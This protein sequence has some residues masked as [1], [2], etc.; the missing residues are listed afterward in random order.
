VRAPSAGPRCRHAVIA[1]ALLLAIAGL[2][3]G[4]AARAALCGYVANEGSDSVSVV[5]LA[6]RRVVQTLAVGDQPTG[7]AIT[8]TDTSGTVVL[9]TNRAAASLSILPLDGT[10][11][12]AVPLTSDPA[13]ISAGA[14]G[15]AYIVHPDTA[16]LTVVDVD[17]IQDAT[18]ISLS[19]RPVAV[20]LAESPPLVLLADESESRLLVLEE[21]DPPLLQP[22]RVGSMPAAIAVD[23]ATGL[24]YVSATPLTVIDPAN[25]DVKG[26]VS[27]PV[28]GTPAGVAMS[29]NPAAALLCVR[30]PTGGSVQ[31][32]PTDLTQPGSTLELGPTVEPIAIGADPGGGAIAFVTDRIG[33]Q[34]L[35]VD[36]AA[37]IVGQIPTGDRPGALAVAA[38]DGPDCWPTPIVGSCA[39]DCNDDGMVAINE[40]II[41]V[42][43]ALG[44][45]TAAQCPAL[46]G[47]ADGQVVIAELISAVAAALGGCL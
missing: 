20:A 12:P 22:Y 11:R 43:I 30:A 31:I 26:T 15:T 8:R 18:A 14:D 37:G 2:T 7:L 6:T 45:A 27:I 25:G 47:D 4:G 39:G 38:V 40:L 5:D 21:V 28:G 32:V 16:T 3:P 44:D 9:V 35:V 13:A 23:P 36:L 24:A 34:L 1:P 29:T 33:D 17:R 19:G 46:D 10:V 41:G 42:T